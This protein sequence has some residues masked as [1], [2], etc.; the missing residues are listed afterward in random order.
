[1]LPPRANRGIKCLIFI[2]RVAQRDGVSIEYDA[3]AIARPELYIW[4]GVKAARPVS[5]HRFLNS[6]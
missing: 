4:H 3:R 6:L 1:V 5:H 2:E